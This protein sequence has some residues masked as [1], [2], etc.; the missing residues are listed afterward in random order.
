MA[1]SC[2]AVAAPAKA[3]VWAAPAG[4]ETFLTVQFRECRIS[5]YYRCA[6]EPEGHVWRADFDVEGLRLL[7]L[8]DAET[9]PLRQID[10][11]G[12][13]DY[14]LDAGSVGLPS[15]SSL[16][17]ERTSIVEYRMVDPA[18]LGEMSVG[19]RFRVTV[20]DRVPVTY[21][22]VTIDGIELEE[23]AFN[24]TRG[25]VDGLVIQE[26]SGTEYVQSDWRLVFSGPEQT[27]IPGNLSKHVQA[28]RSPVDFI[29]PGE[30]KFS[31]TM[32]IEDCELLLSQAD[33]ANSKPT[34]PSD[35]EGMMP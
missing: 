14:Q 13:T 31:S 27:T 12:G 20:P 24:L 25:S 18:G 9:V 26:R 10:P 21:S 35:L 4:C 23:V 28:D 11:R 33:I 3:E 2:L 22:A 29:F 30:P 5:N 7:T 1:A 15:Q 17:S 34:F 8:T 32:P 16:Q 6:A 19:L